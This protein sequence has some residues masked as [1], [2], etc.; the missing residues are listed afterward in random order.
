MRDY[1]RILSLLRPYRGRVLALMVCIFFASAL[2]SVGVTAVSPLVRI[3]FVDDPAAP[4]REAAAEEEAGSGAGVGDAVQAPPV[5]EPGSLEQATEKIVPGHL[6]RWRQDF[7]RRF[8]AWFY[9]GDKAD[10]LMRLCLGLLVLYILRNLFFFGQDA[11]RVWLEQRTIH[12]MRAR[13]YREIQALPLSYFSSARTGYLMSRVIVDVDAMRGAIVGVLTKVVSNTVMV[14]IALTLAASVSWKLLLTTLIIVPP[15]MIL[16]A[17]ISRRL[18]RGSH[19][20]QEEMGN[21]AAILQETIAGMRIV[22]AFDPTG[23]ESHRYDR[24]NHR[25]YKAFVK[26]KILEAMSSP[27]SEILGI[28]TAVLIIATGGRLVIEGQLRPDLLVL[29]LAVILWVIAPIKALIKANSTLQQSLAA[30]RR[31]LEIIDAPKEGARGGHRKEIAPPSEALRFEGVHFSYNGVDPV[32]RGI[33][34]EVPAGQVVALVGPSGAGKSTLVDLVPRFHDPTEG[35]VSLDGVDL[36]EYDLVALRSMIAIV[37]QEV[38]LFHDTVVAN[39]A[40]GQGEIP[41]EQIVEAARAANAHDFIEALPH[42][43]DTVIGE[44]GWQLSG[45]QRQRLAIARAVLRNPPLLILDE[46]T[47]ALDTES[48]RAV[49]DAMQ[50]L[51]VGRT[52]LVIA[53]RLSTITQSDRIVVVQG[54]RIVESGR[55]QELLDA[56]G[57][58]RRLYDLQFHPGGESDAGRDPSELAR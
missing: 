28:L 5:A 15:N 33:D 24:A 29:F 26:L 30:A 19:R 17:W 6:E 39:I 56:G 31:V 57:A 21:T 8:E 16:V 34:L 27:V 53:H 1:L 50:R 13:L 40:Y 23:R 45:G 4:Y 2:S 18:R 22:K 10:M 49:Q 25:Y 35:R 37:S 32:L 46:A 7:S 48:E 52:T 38:I 9:R 54:G 36:R 47:S 11:L 3:L 51:M 20:V 12:D 55:H 58:Y 42:G 43:Y 14:T 44:R 41:R